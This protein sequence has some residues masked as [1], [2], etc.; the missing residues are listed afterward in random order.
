[1]KILHVYKDAYP[2][3]FGGVETFINSLCCEL[4]KKKIY[5]TVVSTSNK[6]KSYI[7]NKFYNLIFFKRNFEIFSTP[8]SIK[9]FFYILREEKN[10]QILHF[11]YP[12]PLIDLLIFFINSKKVVCTYHSDIVKQRFINI[13]FKYFTFYFLKKIHTIVSTSKNYLKTSLVIS[14]FKSK[15]KIVPIGI[16]DEKNKK[17][18]SLDKLKKKDYILYIGANRY[19]KG[20]D[21]I[22][23]AAKID[24]N[25]NFFLC[26]SGRNIDKLKKKIS[27]FNL[28]NVS[29]FENIN[30]N[31]KNFFLKN[32][33]CLILPS[34]H[35][36]EA[37]GIALLEALMFKKP[38][39]STNIGTG[40]SFINKNNET[41]FVIRSK[42]SEALY[43]AIRKIYIKNKYHEMS[44]NA[45]KRYKKFF[46]L[47]KMT[48]NYLKIYK[49]IIYDNK[50]KK[51]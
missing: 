18:Y 21:V 39:I 16:K 5:N 27:R 32:C 6:N 28:D 47:D 10:F 4:S 41:G 11:H 19:Y 17:K 51:I 30:N 37:F 26:I 1:M 29:L 13:I 14:K 25:I 9:M 2:E 15:T 8:L 24:K 33:R 46:T 31:K 44:K 23:D 38:I 40:T 48:K 49:D 43:K 12:Y 7:I 50:F 42:N 45:Y 34:I 22:L 35:R 36:S 3:S 20:I